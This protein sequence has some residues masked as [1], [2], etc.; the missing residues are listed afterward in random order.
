M[1]AA[2]AV[3]VVFV[4]HICFLVCFT[5]AFASAFCFCFCLCFCFCFC[6][7]CV[8]NRAASFKEVPL[9]LGCCKRCQHELQVCFLFGNYFAFAFAFV[10]CC[11]PFFASACYFFL[12]SAFVVVV[13]VQSCSIVQRG[14]SRIGMLHCQNMNCRYVFCLLIILFLLLICSL[15]LC[16]CCCCCCCF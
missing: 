7:C 4:V 12:T 5:F 2:W 11:F 15:L 3:H 10:H 16:C 9:E 8:F 1:A 13:F 14:A 6:F